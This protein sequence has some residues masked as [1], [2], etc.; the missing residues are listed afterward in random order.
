M[1]EMKGVPLSH[2]EPPLPE[3]PDRAG[4]RAGRAAWGHVAP[5]WA[6]ASGWR[7]EDAVAWGAAV[8][9]ETAGGGVSL[10]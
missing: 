9:S 2:S 10:I 5:L 8:G 6:T 3:G 1:S 4:E 7:G